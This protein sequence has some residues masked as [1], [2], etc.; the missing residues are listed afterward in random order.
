LTAAARRDQLLD[1][2]AELLL[3]GGLSTLTMER[4]AEAAG[5]SKGLGYAYFDNIDDLLGALFEREVGNLY[6]RVIDAMTDTKGLDARIRAAVSAYFDAVARHGALL[7]ALQAAVASRPLAR[8]RPDRATNDFLRELAS[9][10]AAELDVEPRVAYA[11]AAA[12]VATAD[13]F[14]RTWKITRLTRTQ[15]EDTC[16]RFILAGLRE[17]RV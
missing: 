8:T 14:G 3:A 16:S 1:T 13:S 12:V 5:A 6:T 17:S 11:H 2:A 15:I 10:L 7:S 4:L 9:V